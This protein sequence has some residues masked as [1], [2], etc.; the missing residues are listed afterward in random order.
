MTLPF[1]SSFLKAMQEAL[2]EAQLCAPS[3]D[4]PVGA[5]VV[6]AAG[7]IV[8]R[9]HN[10]REERNDPTAHAEIEALREATAA[11]G[12]WRLPEAT[13]VV[14][15]EP[16]IMC[17]GALAAAR[18]ARVVFGA[19]DERAGAAGS[20]YDVLRDGR[21]GNSVEVIGGVREQ[22]CAGLLRNF[23]ADRRP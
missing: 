9:G 15:L 2:G 18:V 19:W 1:D 23:F 8:G 7:Q 3:G 6:D 5:V 4:V 14:T 10:R 22:E 12:A 20:V 11:A 21:L 17:A 13:V 16:C